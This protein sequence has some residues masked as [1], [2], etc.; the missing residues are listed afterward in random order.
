MK[1]QSNTVKVA[2]IVILLA[3]IGLLAFSCTPKSAM[4]TKAVILDSYDDIEVVNNQYM[5]KV[6]V[7]TYGIVDSYGDWKLHE[8][9]DTILIQDRWRNCE[10]Q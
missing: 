5:Y 8:Q 1:K 2:I 9:G 7:P 10:I 6:K 3:I 4:M